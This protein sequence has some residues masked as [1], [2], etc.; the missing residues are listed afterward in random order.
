MFNW[1]SR[2]RSGRRPVFAFPKGSDGPTN[3]SIDDNC[4]FVIFIDSDVYRDLMDLGG[5]AGPES[6]EVSV[7]QVL[8]SANKV[9][10]VV[11]GPTPMLRTLMAQVDRAYGYSVIVETSAERFACWA[12]EIAAARDGTKGLVLI[13]PRKYLPA[14]LHQRCLIDTDDRVLEGAISNSQTVH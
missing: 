4:S 9:I 7:P 11:G 3:P 13:G 8:A 14:E 10:V 12:E 5:A 1:K 2:D 6:Y